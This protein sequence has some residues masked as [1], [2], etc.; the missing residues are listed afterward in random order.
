MTH[1]NP[2]TGH[3]RES[4]LFY[5]SRSRRPLI[6]HAK[7]VYMWDVDGKRYIDASSGAMVSNIG[8]SDPRVIAAMNAQLEK[9]SFAYRCILKMMRPKIWHSALPNAHRAILNG[10]FLSLAGQKPSKAASSLPV[11]MPWQKGK[12]SGPRSFR[13]SPAITVQPLVRLPSLAI[14]Q[15]MRPSPR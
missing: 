11:N 14:R 15:C 3:N 5:Q 12:P 10:Y 7:G 2:K 13:V 8:H 1:D 4:R 6:D 9:A